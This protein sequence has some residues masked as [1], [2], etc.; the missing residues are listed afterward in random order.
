MNLFTKSVKYLRTSLP[1]FFLN[2]Y[3]LVF[4]FFLVW[5]LF[6]D[7]YKV[8]N[9]VHLKNRVSEMQLRKTELKQE[10][11]ELK[12]RREDIDLNEEK[13]AREQFLMHRPDEDIFIIKKD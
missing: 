4:C 6:F 2:K 9:Q 7:K 10:I 11:K 5:I 8:F 1:S 12:I 3:F 13:Y